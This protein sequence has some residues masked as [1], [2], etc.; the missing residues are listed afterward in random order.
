MRI[1][2][3]ITSINLGGA[4]NHLFELIQGQLEK[5]HQVQVIYLKG[6]SFWKKSY[7]KMGVPCVHLGIDKYLYLFRFF[8]LRRI[9]KKGQPDIIHAHMPPAE[10]VT[11]LALI[12]NRNNKLVV[13]K[14]NDEP[15][16]PI[17]KNFFLANWVASRSDAI[18]CISR[19]VETYV[20]SW[21]AA[22]QIQKMNLIYYSVDYEKFSRADLPADLAHD[23]N[24]FRIGTVAR[25]T[26][27]KSLHTLLEAF[28]LF[29]KAVPGA[30]L[31]IVG[32]GPLEAELKKMT[33]GLG[34]E[35][36]VRWL[37]K[38]SDV[39]AVMKSFDVFA[40]TSI[41]EGFGLVLL[42]AMAAGIPVIASRVSAIPKVLDNGNCGILFQ[43]GDV[44]DLLAALEKSKNHNERKRLIENAGMR[45]RDDFSRDK[46]TLATDKIYLDLAS[47]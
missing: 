14:H 33:L 44:Q 43:A 34:I 24:I 2:H 25:L 47:D 41:Y 15:F 46:M 26:R 10:L 17:L 7:E 4:E 22:S 36:R 30:E 45:A 16:A 42:E 1:F 38:R 21:I 31:V 35:N 3:V 27:Q 18:I 20:K 28:S 23:K 13:S 19:A 9:I 29:L 12:G 11:R 5:G 8:K 32:V 37:G 40:L 39:P 6:D